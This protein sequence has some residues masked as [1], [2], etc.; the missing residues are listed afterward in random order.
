MKTYDESVAVALAGR[1]TTY[2][3]LHA[4]IGNEPT[5][6][7]VCIFLNQEVY[8]VLDLYSNASKEY[9]IALNDLLEAIRARKEQVEE[10]VD[11]LSID[12]SRLFVGPRKNEV[13]PWESIYRSNE[14]TLF[15]ATTLEVRKAY[16]AQDLIP[17]GY[18]NVADDHIG[19]ELDFMAKLA[20]RAYEANMH[21]DK[22]NLLKALKASMDFL[23]KHLLEWM[24]RFAESFKKA[25]HGEFYGKAANL[26]SLFIAIDRDL[27]GE[28]TQ[29]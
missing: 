14:K 29:A 22:D 27:L 18:P 26:I 10:F 7:T 16:V 9:A 13:E 21:G 11:Q 15:Q 12:Y 19:I 25:K 4:L 28:I 3:L 5:V 20:E 2:K 17:S 24:P 8:E 6:S 23:D 1:T